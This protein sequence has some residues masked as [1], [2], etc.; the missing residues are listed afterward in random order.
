MPYCTKCGN[1]VKPVALFCDQCGKPMPR[2]VSRPVQAAGVS[3]GAWSVPGWLLAAA[4]V[5]IAARPFEH[6]FHQVIWFTRFGAE[7]VT[8]WAAA[9]FR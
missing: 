5:L 1:S 8:E 6:V 4:I 2:A 7:S 3:D 9:L